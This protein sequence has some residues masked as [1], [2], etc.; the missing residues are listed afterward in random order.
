MLRLV[1]DVS[2]AWLVCGVLTLASIDGTFSPIRFKPN[3][4]WYHK[5]LVVILWPLVLILGR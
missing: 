5:V 3:V 2:V 1:L 4:E